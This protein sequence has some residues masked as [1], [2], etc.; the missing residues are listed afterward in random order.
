MDLFLGILSIVQIIFLP[1]FIITRFI[2]IEASVLYIY[3]LSFTLSIAS[4]F[5]ILLLIS[6]FHLTPKILL[7][8]FFIEVIF[9]FYFVL[10]DK[11]KIIENINAYYKSIVETKYDFEKMLF[12]I[13]TVIPIVWIT[14]IIIYNTGTIFNSWDSIV[15][16]NRW[17]IDWY[18]GNYP[19]LTWQ[20]PQMI[21]ANLAVS[22]IFMDK[23]LQFFPKFIMPLF[24]LNILLIFVDLIWNKLEKKY[25]FSLILCALII[26]NS[27]YDFIAEGYVDL[28]VAFFVFFSF[29]NILLFNKN[30]DKK[31]IIIGLIIAVLSTQVKHTALYF[32]CIYPFLFFILSRISN[33]KQI[34][35]YLIFYLVAF[36]MLSAPLIIWNYI[37]VKTGTEASHIEGQLNLFINRAYLDRMIS[38]GK[39][40]MISFG[41]VLTPLIFILL[42]RVIK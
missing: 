18:N 10:K 4:N 30:Y 19:H 1:G 22:Y 8:I 5:Y 11:Q 41:F 29:Y 27:L 25:I 12:I 2:K 33:F 17:A 13:A 38:A 23:T 32:M 37:K 16:Y 15:S 35:K 31:F 14:N 24:T 40:L 36:L 20:Y 39:V 42:L 9:L 7:L 26:N 28:A 21:T 34:F 3:L 6:L